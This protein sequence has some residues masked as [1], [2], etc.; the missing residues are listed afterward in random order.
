M[1]TYYRS[2]HDNQ[3]WLAGLTAVLDTCAITIARLGEVDPYQAQLTF[4]MA[5]HAVVDL[6]QIYSAAPLPSDSPRLTEAGEGRLMDALRDSGFEVR[7]HEAAA[8]RYAELR[9]MYEP[10]VEALARHFVLRLPP[11]S[12]EAPVVDNW[13]TSAW[14]RRTAGIGGLAPGADDHDG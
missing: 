11:I 5:R 9:G 1:L 14:M 3:S 12:P 10:F 7:D 13:Q 2:Q 4:A 6:S 8:A